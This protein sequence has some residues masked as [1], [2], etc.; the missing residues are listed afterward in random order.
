MA[1]PLSSATRTTKRNLLIASVL[2]ISANAFNISIEKIPLAGL[3]VNFDDRLFTFLLVL[4]LVYFLGTFVLYYFIDIKNLEPTAH[5]GETEQRYQRRLRVFP[6]QYSEMVRSEIEK[7][8]PE[9]Y[10]LN[11]TGNVSET[12][13]AFDLKYTIR[14]RANRRLIAGTTDEVLPRTEHETVFSA[15]DARL[16][17]W[18]E[19]YPKAFAKNQRRARATVNSIR[20]M[21]FV[22]NYVVDG[23]LPI[24]LG[25]LAV[26]SVLAH[27]DLHWIQ[28]FLPTFK[29]LSAPH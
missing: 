24:V 6:S 28:T 19:R 27:M 3:S 18:T 10:V 16:A 26:T 25:L 4:T 11:T 21:Y 13:D 29:T 12:G 7:L 22:R 15:I 8:I 2:A 14:K 1:D 9:G 23:A 5:Q 20:T 17:Y